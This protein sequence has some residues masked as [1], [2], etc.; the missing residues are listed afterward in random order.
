MKNRH[1]ED[2]GDAYAQYRPTYPA[3]LAQ[4]LAN[5]CPTKKLAIDVGC[6]NGQ[7][8]LLLAEHFD[9][10]LASDVSTDQIA[11]ATAHPAIAYNVGPAEKIDA[12]DQSADLVVAA[13]AAHW[14]DLPAFYEDAK[15]VLKPSG[16]IA[17]ITY[18][19]L[20]VDGPASQRIDDF[21]WKEIHPF[22]PKGRENVENGY[23]DFPFPF[24]PI[25]MPSL[26]IERTWSVDHFA[27][28]CNTWSAGKRAKAAGRD[29]II[30]TMRA[31]VA[32]IIDTDGALSI[33]WPITIRAGRV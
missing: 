27:N 4:T 8:S 29:D 12:K 32:N 2:R 3:H 17:L 23:K 5:S 26:A 25:E 24:E 6:G 10:V 18:G 7:F 9:T 30:E 31:D 28:Y 20:E 22:W 13:Q 33:R 1:F 21:Y 11:N 15:R 14:F 16:I 19:V